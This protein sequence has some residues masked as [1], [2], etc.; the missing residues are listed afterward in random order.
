MLE[1]GNETK[2]PQKTTKH[3]CSWMNDAALPIKALE[4]SSP[5]ASRLK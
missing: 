5:P 3:P 2:R 1:H 4:H